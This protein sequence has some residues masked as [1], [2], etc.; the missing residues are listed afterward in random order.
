MNTSNA[1]TVHAFPA[2]SRGLLPNLMVLTHYIQ[3]NTLE[4]LVESGR[5]GKL[6]LA[7]EGYISLL[8]ERDYAPG[9]L[10]SRLGVSKQLAS[11][12]IRDLERQ[13]LIARHKHPSDSRSSL[14]SL[15]D[16]G[17]QLLRDGIETTNALHEQFAEELGA[18]SLK[19][20]IAIV[21]KLSRQLGIDLPVYTRFTLPDSR[22]ATAR[23][24]KLNLLLPKLSAHF[25]LSLLE[26]LQARGFKGLRS[27]FGQV[28]GVISREGKKIQYIAAVI[29]VSKQSIA[30]TANE[31]ERL[32]YIVREQDPLDRR[33]VVLR[34]SENGRRLLAASVEDVRAIEALVAA[35]LTPAEFEH[36]QD[37]LARLYQL[38]ASHFDTASVLPARIQQLSKNLIE[39]LGITGARALAQQLMTMT[40]GN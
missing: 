26:S 23:P 31:L 21:E 30:A 22:L 17:L 24:N 36:L 19:Q 10:A 12:T 13:G 37:A 27:G 38:V 9:E 1:S 25:R 35:Q 18:E 29:G 5:Y 16:K 34:L 40:R 32:D 3:K 4:K 39:E 14:L 33:E 7:Y 8:A 15:T 6:S 28:M 2:A 20:L 11:K